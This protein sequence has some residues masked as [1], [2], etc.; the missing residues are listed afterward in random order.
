MNLLR[1]SLG[2]ILG[3]F[4]V[5]SLSAEPA[6]G[7][8]AIV[9]DKAITFEEVNDYA[10]PAIQALHR[11]YPDQSGD[12]QKKL[13]QIVQDTLDQLIERQLILR[14]YTHDGYT[15]LPDNLV[16]QL[17]KDRIRDNFGDR[18]TLIKTLQARGMTME[19]YRQT[20]RDQYIEEAMRNANIQK[21]IVI[22]P[23]RIE[24][25][26]QAHKEDYRQEDEVKLRMIYLKK[27][28]EGDT[29]T[30][31]M[32]REIREK[33][34]H[35]ADFAQMADVYSQDA[36]QHQGGDR[37]WVEHSV[38]RQDLAAVAFR[39]EAGQVSEVIDTPE[40]SYL[41]LVEARKP[42]HYRPLTEIRNDIEKTLR[43]Q[44]QARLERNWIER[45]KQKNFI[46]YL[47]AEQRIAY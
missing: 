41:L 29:R 9:N 3:L 36:Q 15:P 21:E 42:A 31:A 40:A 45:L 46:R 11:E 18:V 30:L 6:D 22:S 28:G 2:V 35:G 26:Y 27:T 37:G 32:A 1:P 4:A 12:Y 47:N 23:Y 13:A 39:L 19:K 34:Q 17:V 14:S 38:L 43:S 24:Q 16:D 44:E 10:A 5:L 20:V 25:Y 33:I 8:M 7:I